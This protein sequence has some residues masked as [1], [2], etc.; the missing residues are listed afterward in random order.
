MAEKLSLRDYQRDLA[1]RLRAASTAR[2][3]SLLALQVGQEG[4][5]VN[6]ADAGEVIPL[7][8]ITP[9]PL[10]KGW[11]R[12]MANIRG[13]LYSVVDFAAYLGGAPAVQGEQTRLLL[14]GDRFRLGAAL[15]VD[16]SL[17][18]RNPA[19]LKA[20]ARPD[21]APQWLKAQ[22]AD[23]D[24]RLWKELDVPQLVQQQEFLTVGA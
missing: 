10:T 17:G 20:Q 13:N 1:E 2:A 21:D 14:L 16:R 15:L 18:L 5:L 7:P 8:A 6:L 12:G 22:H 4:W 19:Q 9:V 3:A 23:E 24:G 11:F